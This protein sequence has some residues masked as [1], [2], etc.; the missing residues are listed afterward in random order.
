MCGIS[1]I[2]INSPQSEVNIKELMFNVNNSLAHRG[3]DSDGY[4]INVNCDLFL[5]HQRLAILDLT[6]AGNQPMIS[7]NKRYIICFNGEIYNH[8]SIRRELEKAQNISNDYWAGNSDTETLLAALEY[9]DLEIVLN[10]LVGMFAF[11]LYDINENRLTLVRDRFGEKPLYFG[12]PFF[13]GLNSGKCLFFASELI[14]FKALKGFSNNI[15]KEA[16]FCYTK[17]GYVAAPLSVYEGIY[18]LMPGHYI[19]FPLDSLN[20]NKCRLM[21]DDQIQWW[22]PIHISQSFSANSLTSQDEFLERLELTLKDSIKGQ[23]I[24]DVPLGAFLSGGIDSTLITTLLQMQS[25]DPINT[26]TI[27]F[28]DEE[29]GYSGFDEAG[30]T[31]SIASYLGTNHN[32][33]VLTAEDALKLIPQLPLIFSEPFSDSSQVATH[34]V[35]KEARQSGLSVALSGDGADELFGGYNRHRIAP[36]LNNFLE[37]LPNSSKNFI[38]N[39]ID[40][41]KVKDKGLLLEKRRKLSG[42]IRNSSSLDNIYNYL[43]SVFFDPSEIIN[44]SIITNDKSLLKVLPIAN[45]SE[46][47]IMMAD[48]LNYLPNDILVKLDRCAMSNSL[49]T[50]SPYLDHRLAEISWQMPINMKIPN[51]FQS[52]GKFALRKIL[53]KYIPNNLVSKRKSGFAIPLGKWLRGPLKNWAEDLLD[54]KKMELEGYYQPE[55][56]RSIWLSHLEGKQDNYSKLWNILMWQAWFSNK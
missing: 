36:L 50:R 42:A 17:S 6:E 4:W 40:N 7:K 1:G 26:F 55:K 21:F 34:L 15:N 24:S 30:N 2:W 46:E 31:R 23:S 16:F 47:Q 28:P 13:S 19:S 45:T 52:T 54:Y 44:K 5:S 32:E 56:V 38:A 11:G 35:C 53:S 37:K 8:I 25:S 41:F 27:S 33:R 43:S 14:A 20:I 3:P 48:L 9:W 22:D 29:D 49:E 51:K 39:S 12:I 18:Q 10:K